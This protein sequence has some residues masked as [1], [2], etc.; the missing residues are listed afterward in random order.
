MTGK[1]KVFLV[2]VIMTYGGVQVWIH[3][4]WVEVSGQPQPPDALVPGKKPPP[5]L[6]I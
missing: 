1:R 6:P 4:H 2:H 5:T 3:W